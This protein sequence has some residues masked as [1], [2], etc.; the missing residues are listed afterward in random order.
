M[1]GKTAGKDQEGKSDGLETPPFKLTHLGGERCVTGSCH[2][3]QARGL[4]I[5]VDCGMVQGGDPALSLDAW[6][7]SP[8]QIDYVLLTHA[9]IDHIGRLPELVRKGFHGEILATHPTKT[10]LPPMLRD[11]LSFSDWGEKEAEATLRK[12]DDLSWGFEYG[13][14]FALKNGVRFTFHRAGHI[15]G[16]AFILLESESPRSSILFSG[17]LGAKNTPLLPD[18]DPPPPCNLLVL[19]S[20]YGNRL[21]ESR[22]DR[23]ERLGQVL[24]GALSDGGKVFIP[25]FALG[26]AQEVLYELDRLRTDDALREKFPALAKLQRIPVM[27]DSP[28]GLELTKIASNLSAYWDQEAKALLRRGDHPLNFDRLYAVESYKNHREL[29]EM[30]G[31]MVILAGSGMCTGGRIIDHLREGIEDP[32]NDIVFVGYQAHGTPGRSIQEYAGKPGGYVDLDGDRRTI[33][34]QVHVLGG[35]SAHA[36][37]RELLD[38]VQSMREKPGSIKLVHGEAGARRALGN[39]LRSRGYEVA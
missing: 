30:P 6:P 4:N 38:W 35:Y 15:L 13:E 37:Q 18:P 16:S 36:D 24:V 34:A 14:P 39:V 28:L 32:R 22:A 21:H 12:L 17:D 19:E 7:V 9:H 5:L 20:T 2:L 3:V 31:P 27:V 10:L 11:A 8:P 33:R 1:T 29:L 26:R 25:A 23:V